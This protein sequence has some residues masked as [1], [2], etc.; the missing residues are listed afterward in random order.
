M[1]EQKEEKNNLL[2]MEELAAQEWDAPL[3]STAD[4]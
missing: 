2:M 4:L 1:N 3:T